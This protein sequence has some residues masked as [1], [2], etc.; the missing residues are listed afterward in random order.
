MCYRKV[1]IYSTELQPV[2]TGHV[3][4]VNFIDIQLMKLGPKI[5][6]TNNSKTVGKKY[7]R[8]SPLIVQIE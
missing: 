4:L 1:F 5:I 3:S 2:I 7:I 6:L 8:P